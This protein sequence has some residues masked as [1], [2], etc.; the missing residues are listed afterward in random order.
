MRIVL[1]GGVG[2]IGTNIA[3]LAL[4]KGHTVIACDNLVRSGV[5][6]NLSF[7]KHYPRFSFR[8]CDVRSRRDVF[9]SPGSF[10]C[11]VNLAANP[12]IAK[13]IADPMFDFEVNLLGHINILEFARLHG[14]IPV[15]FASSNKV[16]TDHINTF[17]TRET[18]TRYEFTDSGLKR[19]FSEETNTDGWDGYTNTPYGVAKLAAE[20]YT[21]EYGKQY[22]IPTVINRMSCIYGEFQKGVEDQGWVD[23]FLRAKKQNQPLTIYGD[24]KQ[25]RDVLFG[26]DVAQLYVYEIEHMDAVSGRTFNVGGGVKLGFHTSLL[27]L[28]ALID[29][30]FPG[31]PIKLRFKPWRVNDQRIYLSDITRVVKVTGWKPKTKLIDGLRRMWKAYDEK[32]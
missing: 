17:A 32:R 1:F 20:K 31:K 11:I 3:R 19:G 26:D 13:G 28:V 9:S 16:Y 4:E 24:G 10:D 29:Q 5:E 12:G 23:W 21:R 6:R 18:D 7:L 25:V 15:I 2:F 8:R 22:D 27:E 14:K 30:S